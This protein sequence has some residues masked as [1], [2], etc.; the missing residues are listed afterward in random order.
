MRYLAKLLK[1]NHGSTNL[2]MMIITVIVF[3]VFGLL[4][5]AIIAGM[6]DWFGIGMKN[7]INNIL[8]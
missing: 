4:V 6:N 3:V 7:R 5:I 2:S 8:N 1:D